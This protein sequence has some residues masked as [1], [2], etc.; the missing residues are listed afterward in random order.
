MNV[1][2]VADVPE[3]LKDWAYSLNTKSPDEVPA[4]SVQR[5]Y[6]T[7]S[8]CGHN[9]SDYPKGKSLNNR[10]CRIC[11]DEE[12]LPGYNDFKTRYPDK[13]D[14]IVDSE[15]LPT[16]LNPKSG[17]AVTLFCNLD[18]NFNRTLGEIIRG[19]DKCP[20]C[21]SKSVLFGFNDLETKFPEIAK[22][23]HPDWNGSL[24]PSTVFCYRKAKAWWRC[25]RDHEWE[26][27]IDA[28]T[29]QNQGC[30]YCSG[31][32]AIPGE[33][34]LATKFPEIAGNWHPELNGDL[35][36]TEIK[37]F[38][39]K[40]VWWTCSEGHEDYRQQISKRTGR[41]TGC[42]ECSKGRGNSK[43]EFQLGEFLKSLDIDYIQGSRKFLKG[44][45]LDFYIE[46]KSFGLEYNGEWTHSDS[47][48]K[49]NSMDSTAHDY[50][51]RKLGQAEAS[52]VDLAF[53]W[54]HDWEEHR[55]D[56]ERA[57]ASW[58]NTEEKS[59]LLTRTVS[60]KDMEKDCCLVRV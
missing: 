40:F 31:K 13:L 59:P 47:A 46:S 7:S 5:F 23:F 38:A 45:E 36:P 18:H 28:R 55:P 14:R 37:P 26:A 53:V 6:W 19:A 21:L 8:L 17:Y 10:G 51:L 58:L 3:L 30:P 57:I 25:S 49:P 56:V 41:G 50:H 39:H 42:P 11:S 52:S 27:R 4:K 15:N 2:T 24:T 32:L 22:E 60:F 48:L 35:K 43:G 33:T 20:I 16:D 44:M 29:G 12:I 1:V 54:E 34:D 9:W